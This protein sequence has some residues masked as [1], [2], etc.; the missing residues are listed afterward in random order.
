M[1]LLAALDPFAFSLALAFGMLIVYALAPAPRLVC[2]SPVS[3]KIG[4][5][6]DE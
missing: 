2:E 6:M 3:S 5:V 4:A 1:G